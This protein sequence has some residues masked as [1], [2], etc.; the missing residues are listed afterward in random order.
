MRWSSFAVGPAA[1]ATTLRTT[2]T[3]DQGLRPID[4][5]RCSWSWRV[6]GDMADVERQERGTG[7]EPA[8]ARPAATTRPAEGGIARAVAAVG[9]RA[10][11]ER[12]VGFLAAAPDDSRAGLV[13]GLQRTVGNR[14]VGR[15]IQRGALQRTVRAAAADAELEADFQT[16]KTELDRVVYSPAVEAKVLGILR[17]WA[18]EPGGGGGEERAARSPHLD[19]LLLRLR[20]AT[21][22]T[23]LF[24]TVVSYYDLMF[25]HFDQGAE[26][27]QIRD[28]HSRLFVG[29]E[30]LKQAKFFGTEKD[31]FFGDLW[32]D[33]KS[34]AAE[35]RIYA[36]FRGLV[37]AG[38]GLVEG[39]AMLLDPMQ[40]PKLAEAIGNLPKTAEILWQNR[41]KFWNDFLAAK[42]EEQAR[43]VGRVIGEIEIQLFSIAIGV[44][45]GK[46]GTSAPALAEA[47]ATMGRGGAAM[48]T[49]STGITITI[50]LGK[51][52]P[53]GQSLILMSQ[54]GE[55]ATKGKG[56]ADAVKAAEGEA[57][58]TGNTEPGPK[59]GQSETPTGPKALGEYGPYSGINDK[60][61]VRPGRDFT[62]SQKKRIRAANRA[63][64]NGRLKSDDPLD[65]YQDLSEPV[66]SVSPGLGGKP[67]D[68]AMAAVDHIVSQA[69]GGTNG[70]GNARVI[71]QFFNNLL[72]AKGLR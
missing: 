48:G 30:P 39:M 24:D 55:G 3:C 33:V 22:Q 66:K 28:H 61:A 45:A 17:R 57:A 51:L 65:P 20:A 56:E 64:N 35:R 10:D 49:I 43:I 70:Y 5:T 7:A 60:T 69:A 11:P 31:D 8:A 71:S 53:A 25:E 9:L 26:L 46:A 16:I 34:G 4:L 72:R 59:G 40:W 47:T 18:L 21:K 54:V 38:V 19:K 2:E 6:R 23:G 68:P 63:R 67:Q 37:E 32:E 62:D 44:G 1:G 52:G 42:P 14:A 15:L 29:E 50:D 36:Y 13:D 41:E 12:L 27:R 58:G